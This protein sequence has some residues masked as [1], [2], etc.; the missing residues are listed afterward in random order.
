MADIDKKTDD[1]REKKHTILTKGKTIRCY[2]QTY[3]DIE[4]LEFSFKNFSRSNSLFHEPITDSEFT[5]KIL[6]SLI[7]SPQ[8]TLLDFSDISDIELVK[9]VQCYCENCET[10]NPLFEKMGEEPVFRKFRTAIKRYNDEKIQNMISQFGPIRIPCLPDLSNIIPPQIPYL[11][12]IL[13]QQQKIYDQLVKPVERLQKSLQKFKITVDIANKILKKYKWFVSLGLPDQFYAEVIRIENQSGNKKKKMNDLFIGYF[14]QNNFK[15]LEELIEEWD[16]NPLFKPRMKI[17]RNCLKTLR[18]A[19][20][21]DNP[22]IV[23]IPVLIAQIDGIMNQI[24]AKYEIKYDKKTKKWVDSNGN[25]SD[26]KEDAKKKVIE[27][28]NEYSP[29]GEF[30]LLEILFQT[31]LPGQ[32]LNIP[33][34]F[35]RHKIMH[36]E[37]I[38]YGRMENTIRTFLILDFLHYLED[39]K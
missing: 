6:Y 13:Q 14:S 28:L 4:F 30:V 27:G 11:Q 17:F 38:N 29:V 10:L 12:S 25:Y 35:S 37:K 9:I 16:K 8:I 5:K 7:I 32:E 3:G 24:I 26:K 21:K 1:D 23:V 19:K 31:A 33:T 39:L 22:S 34:A 15:R 18:N 2:S 20:K 36:G